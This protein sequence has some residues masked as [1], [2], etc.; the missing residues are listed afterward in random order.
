MNNNSKILGFVLAGGRSS[1]MKQDKTF[2]ELAGRSFLDIQIENLEKHDL[3]VAISS[4]TIQKQHYK[5]EIPVIPDYED[6]LFIGPLAG[7]YAGLTYARQHGYDFILT[8]P[9]DCPIIP[10]A[11]FE[12]FIQN[13]DN[14]SV[15]C[16]AKTAAGLQPTFALWP[17]A[18]IDELKDFLSDTNN[19]SIRA[20]AF[21]KNVDI[22]EFDSDIPTGAFF[23]IN[24]PDDYNDSKKY[25]GENM[26]QKHRV[27]GV[28]GWK[29]NGKTTMVVRIVEELTKRGY[30]IATV[31]HAHHDFDIDHENTDSW[32]HRKAGAQEVAVVSS[33][34]FAIIHENEIEQDVPLATILERLAP[35][36]LVIVE[37]YKRD[38]HD[39]LE[40]RRT[41]GKEGE[42]LF[43][44]DPHI[45]A[46]ASDT[47]VDDTTLP[48]FDLDDISSIVDFIETH[49]KLKQE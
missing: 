29:N 21:A 37:G 14:D 33:R 45:V 27:F 25:F 46:I 12:K 43:K 9:I 19:K 32:K 49:M 30:K 16:M 40:V 4:N 3:P 6:Q 47:S 42:P 26:T 10:D 18:L 13:I 7:I 31:K 23:N 17:V 15:F 8:I 22:I 34:R 44:S 39:K 5:S 24:T 28:T 41:G 38:S 36:D 48:V 20:F 2:L 1:R 35:C 11:F